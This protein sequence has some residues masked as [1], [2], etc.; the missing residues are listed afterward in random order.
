MSRMTAM[1]IIIPVLISM[2]LSACASS[3]ASKP[4]YVIDEPIEGGIITNK[5]DPDAPKEI[6]S[7]N[8]VSFYTNISLPNRWKGDR[9]GRGS[10]D[11]EFEIKEDD[12]GILTAYEH[13]SC[14]R[15]PANDELLQSLQKV[16]R[17]YNL[18]SRNGKYSI[19]AGIDPEFGSPCEFSA[20]YDT[21]EELKFTIDNEPYSEWECDIYDVFAKWF[22]DNGIDALY[23]DKYTAKATRFGITVY[24]NGEEKCDF[25]TVLKNTDGEYVYTLPDDYYEKVTK[26]LA[27]YDLVFRYEYSVYN[28]SSGVYDNHENGYF[29][30]GDRRPDYSEPDSEDDYVD[31]YVEYDDGGRFGIETQ[32]KSEIEA[33]QPML[34]ELIEYHNNITGSHFEER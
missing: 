20:T 19:T 1:A 15:H 5:T 23:P 26:I 24:E 30:F 21:G 14:A 28:F 27:K 18:V 11:F 8:I 9:E 3:G 4:E 32:K 6:G 33:M 22:S 31:I 16:I 13:I 10:H 29:G 17:D 2:V 25:S 7:D 34:T 12:S